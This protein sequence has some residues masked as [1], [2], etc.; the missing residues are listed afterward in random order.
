MFSSERVRV[1]RSPGIPKAS[2]F[3][4]EYTA[5]G[6][7]KRHYWAAGSSSTTGQRPP[8]RRFFGRWFGNRGYTRRPWC[9][10][11]R[12]PPRSEDG[13]S[14]FGSCTTIFIDGLSHGLSN[15]SLKNLFSMKVSIIDSFISRKIRKASSSAFGF[16]RFRSRV[17]AIDAIKEIDGVVLRGRK[18]KASLA[19][20]DKNGMAFGKKHGMKRNGLMGRNMNM[21]TTLRQRRTY[22]DIVTGLKKADGDKALTIRCTLSLEE[23][24]DIKKM[25]ESAVMAEKLNTGVSTTLMSVPPLSDR[26]KGCGN[27]HSCRNNRSSPDAL[28]DKQQRILSAEPSLNTRPFRSMINVAENGDM[29]GGDN[30]KI[31]DN[32]SVFS[33]KDTDASIPRTEMIVLKGI[34]DTAVSTLEEISD[35]GVSTV[36]TKRASPRTETTRDVPNT[37]SV[38]LEKNH[39]CAPV[40]SKK[41]RNFRD[42]ANYLGYYGPLKT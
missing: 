41:S 10:G 20:Y 36:L 13:L 3:K 22:S 4:F 26:E 33:T 8:L 25:L 12:E 42:I 40:T 18:L 38:F 30:E 31:I 23:N 2:K 7:S 21:V 17:E 32:D 24:Q 28:K 15:F 5:H 27:D 14:G 9:R 37:K 39:P 1:S 16:A 19:K 34:P 29:G 35:T 6:K 11:P